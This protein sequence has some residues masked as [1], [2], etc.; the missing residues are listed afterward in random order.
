MYTRLAIY[1][2]TPT[3]SG[4]AN[5]FSKSKRGT[6]QRVAYKLEGKNLLRLTWSVLDRPPHIEPSRR[7][8]LNGVTGMNLGFLD[9]KNQIINAWTPNATTSMLPNA[10]VFTLTLQHHKTLRSVFPIAG[11]GFDD[12]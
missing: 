5:P 12:Q 2:T 11:R 7:I 1:E 4:Y 6:L 10:I 9:N 8:M 3:T